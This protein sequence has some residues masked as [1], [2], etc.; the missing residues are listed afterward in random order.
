MV[1]IFAE[2]LSN[3]AYAYNIAHSNDNTYMEYRRFGSLI[4]LNWYIEKAEPFD[5]EIEDKVTE[6]FK[7]ALRKGAAIN[8]TLSANINGSFTYK[9]LLPKSGV[10]TENLD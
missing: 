5:N 10:T 6:Y 4:I 1:D 7:M 8:I 9:I 2:G 3:I